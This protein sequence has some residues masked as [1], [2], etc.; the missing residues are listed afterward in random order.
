MRGLAGW[1]H[2][3]YVPR[4]RQWVFDAA[5][6]CR[7]LPPMMAPFLAANNNHDGIQYTRTSLHSQ[8][9]TRLQ[10]RRAF[11]AMSCYAT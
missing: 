6:L 2:V 5:A 7:G 1:V 10:E 8:F 9:G 3:G 4:P 11:T